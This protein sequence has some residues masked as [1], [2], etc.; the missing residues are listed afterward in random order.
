MKGI[1]IVFTCFI[2]LCIFLAVKRG[3]VTKKQK[4]ISQEF[5]DKEQEANSVRRQSL[6]SLPYIVIPTSKLPF[7]E[8]DDEKISSLQKEIMNLSSKKIVN[9]SGKSNTDLKLEYGAPNL[10]ELTMMDEN[11]I[12]LEHALCEWGEALADSGK[13]DEAIS[14]LEFAVTCKSDIAKVYTK[15]ASLYK[16]TDDP[17]KIYPLIVSAGEIGSSRKDS[18]VDSLTKILNS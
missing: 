16:Y 2:I 7:M 17:S 1:P 11:F 5:W 9:F 10:P 4:N 12:R 6:E 14:V 8:T 13:S 15:L 3:S 18:I